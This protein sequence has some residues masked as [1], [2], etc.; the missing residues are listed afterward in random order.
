MAHLEFTGICCLAS[1]PFDVCY[2]MLMISLSF[3][4]YSY[5]LI[6]F[7]SGR[8]VFLV[9]LCLFGLEVRNGIAKARLH[10]SLTRSRSMC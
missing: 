1:Y 6:S 7:I 10:V 2:D 5:L 3:W 9:R 4:K 8:L